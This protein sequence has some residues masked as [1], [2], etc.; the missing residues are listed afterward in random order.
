LEFR[1]QPASFTWGVCAGISALTLLAWTIFSLRT[2][3]KK[4]AG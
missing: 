1:Y 3:G 4:P 2:K